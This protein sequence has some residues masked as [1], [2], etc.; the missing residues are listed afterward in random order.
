MKKILMILT[1]H[2][3]MEY[4]TNKTGVWLGEFTEPYYE[5]VDKGYEVVLASPK[6]GEPPID[7]MSKLTVHMTGSNLRFQEDK[8]AQIKFENTLNL[9]YT[10]DGN[11]VEIIKA[12]C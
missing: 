9:E 11:E 12:E 6:G 3:D 10:I 8:L 2:Q 5:F 7:P 1:S 4:T